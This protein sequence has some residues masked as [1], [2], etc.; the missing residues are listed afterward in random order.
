MFLSTTSEVTVETSG[1][2]VSYILPVRPLGNLR[3]FGLIPVGFGLLFISVPWSMFGGFVKNL[4]TG[5]ING[6][7]I[8]FTIFLIPF[9]IAGLV[10]LSIGLFVICGRC[11]IDW[12]NERLSVLDYAGLIRWRRRFPKKTIRKFTVGRGN[13]QAQ[14]EP[15]TSG[16]LV[17]LGALVAEFEEGKPRLMAIGYPQEWLQSIA[18]DLATHVGAST[19]VVTAPQVETTEPGCIESADV[20]KPSNTQIQ[21]ENRIGEIRINVPSSG[22]RKGSKG[23]FGFA[24][25]WCLFMS[26]ISSVL[27]F[28]KTTHGIPWFVFLMLALFWTIGLGMLAGAI[29]MSRRRFTIVASRSELKVAQT[30][31]FGSREWQWPR[32]EIVAVR[33][34]SSG[35]KINN[36]P[37]LELQILAIGRKKV[38]VMAGRDDQELRWLATE[39]RKALEIPVQRMDN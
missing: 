27:I 26:V 10:P 13:P 35:M 16:P 39:L 31:P 33:A 21:L 9:F 18:E 6:P 28:G 11:R 15:I 24:I 5:G 12:R 22:L 25:F 30:G 23:F 34:D 4:L 2:D 32:S 17:N 29:N 3:W 36:V 37:I 8:F 7:E 1:N 19:N 38:G 14:G 20:D